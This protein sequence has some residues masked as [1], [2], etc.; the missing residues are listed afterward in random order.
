LHGIASVVL[1]YDATLHWIA[2]VVL[3]YDATLHGIPWDGV[4]SAF[5]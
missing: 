5:L 1:F 2:S 3:F 4:S